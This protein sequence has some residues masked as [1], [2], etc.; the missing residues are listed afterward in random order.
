[1]SDCPRAAEGLEI[2]EVED[3]LVV[4]DPQRD[5]VHHL[6]PTA[7]VVLTF[8]TGE[9]ESTEMVSL[10]QAVY[11][12]PTPPADEVRDCLHQLRDEGLIV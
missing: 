8:C 11:E 5:R 3:G 12:L 4:Y 1:M 7:G 6:N 2:N 9:I 10:L